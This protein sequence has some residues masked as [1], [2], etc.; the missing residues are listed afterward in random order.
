MSSRATYALLL[1][2]S[3]SF[4]ARRTFVEY[5]GDVMASEDQPSDLA[6]ALR[7]LFGD[8]EVNIY[9]DSDAEPP[10]VSE[11]TWKEFFEDSTRQVQESRDEAWRTYQGYLSIGLPF[12]L[13][14]R[15]FESEAY[16]YD[17]SGDTER[18][19]LFR[20]KGPRS[21]EQHVYATIHQRIP[22]IALWSPVD[23]LARGL[24]PRFSGGDEWEHEVERL[25]R[26]AAIIV[27]HCYALSPG[28]N[29]ELNLLRRCQREAATVIVLNDVDSPPD[30]PLMVR[31]RHEVPRKDHPALVGF[32]R[33][34][35]EGEIDWEQ[36][37]ASPFLGDL[38]RQ[39]AR[40]QDAVEPARL[41]E[42]TWLPPGN[43]LQVLQDRARALRVKGYL[44]EA[45]T[46]AADALAVAKQLGDPENIAA[47][48]ITV[49]I[50]ALEMDRLDVAQTAFHASGEIFND[51][52]DK[53]GEATA[54]A[55]AGRTYAKA[56][57]NDT[58]VRFFLIALQRW[59]ELDA[60]DGMIDTLQQ[61]A[62]LLD[63]ISTT[64]K[65]HPGV[66]QAAKLIEQLG[67]DPN[68]QDP[69]PGNRRA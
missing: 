35:Y 3:L 48:Q 27:F 34:A 59:S 66:Q 28:V 29:T 53:D 31:T 45:A 62:P 25:A 13:F 7:D 49:G 40:R 57:R 32:S 54:A 14:L 5:R 60:T 47:I 63:G 10:L 64:T 46:A 12:G 1:A 41:P 69:D 15:A 58:A 33:V 24:I 42:L 44:E 2:H 21:V 39:A 11:A 30:D 18:H 20:L 52:G 56:G 22:F 61:M 37:E 68:R 38:L 26:Q 16:R 4:A 19:E 65:R 50:V 17:L 36:P 67:L 43:R 8:S 6:K 55:W 51:L 23:L 9:S